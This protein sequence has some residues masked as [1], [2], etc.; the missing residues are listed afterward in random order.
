MVTKNK[1]SESK[2]VTILAEKIVKPLILNSLYKEESILNTDQKT[3]TKSFVS[4]SS[5]GVKPFKSQFCDKTSYSK[6]GLK[7]HITKMHPE[8]KQNDREETITIDDEI[9]KEATKVVELLLDEII[10]MHDEEDLLDDITIE[11][12]CVSNVEKEKKIY[13]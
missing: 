1:E 9:K 3:Q 7:G 11:E 4:V 2:Y 8:S 10:E 5:K 12:D 6:P 13:K